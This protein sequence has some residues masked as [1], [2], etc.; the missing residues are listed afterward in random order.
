MAMAMAMALALALAL[1]MA[2]LKILS[3]CKEGSEERI[4]FDRFGLKTYKGVHNEVR[5]LDVV[6]CFGRKNHIL[7][8]KLEASAIH[9]LPLLRASYL[10]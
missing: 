4:F 6:L 9:R 2:M 5:S 1:A 3:F 10:Q 8:G 7:R